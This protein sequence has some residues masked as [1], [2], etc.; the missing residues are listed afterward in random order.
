[1]CNYNFKLPVEPVTLFQMFRQ[2]IVDHGGMVS[3]ELPSVSVSVPTQVGRVEG[4]CQLLDDAMVNIQITKKPDL[5]T[6]NMVR[7]NLVAYL[8]EAVKAYSAQTTTAA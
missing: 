3:G 7:D 1:M 4:K 2:Q 8:T 6:C 5:V